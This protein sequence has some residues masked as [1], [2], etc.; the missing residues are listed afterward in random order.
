M[1]VSM[2]QLKQETAKIFDKLTEE[3]IVTK[4]G[5]PVAKIVPVAKEEKKKP[6]LGGL[7]HLLVE[8][9]D[10]ISP[11]EDEWEANRE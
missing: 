5:V 6:I 7:K 9:G 10:V 2:T 1:E 3:V 4:R 8:M 11:I